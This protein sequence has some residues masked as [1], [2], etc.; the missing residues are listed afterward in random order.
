MTAA[1]RTPAVLAPADLPQLKERALAL[2]LMGLLA[3]WDGVQGD[4]AR[5]AWTGELLGWEEAE[6]A[7]RSLERRLRSAHIG[8]FKPLADFDWDW[9]KQC[10]RTAVQELMMLSFSQG[11][12]H[13]QG[14]AASLGQAQGGQVM[15]RRRP[16]PA[17]NTRHHVAGLPITLPTDWSPEQSVAVFEILDELR[18]RVWDHYGRQIQQVLRAQQCTAAPDA[19]DDIDEADVPF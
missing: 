3:H 9:P 13:A 1:A 10:D 14:R 16:V 19:A 2:R 6:R 15:T 11:A 5:T 8:R 17:A 18:E 4:P 12:C 7:R